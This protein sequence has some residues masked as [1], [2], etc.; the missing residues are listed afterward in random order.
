MME[1]DYVLRVSQLNEYVNGMLRRETLLQHIGVRGEISGLKYHASGH[2]YFSLKDE[3]ALLRC[4]MFKTYAARLTCTLRDGM[5]IVT[6]GSVSLFVR[7]GQF[8]LY[9]EDVQA[10]GEGELYRRFLLMKTRLEAQGLFDAAHKRPLPLLPRRIG[11]VTSPSGAVIHDIV[12]VAGRRF[13]TMPILLCPVQV[14]GPGAAEEI[15]A[16]IRY[17][18]AHR[19]ADVLIV[20]RGGGSM[21]DLWAFNEETVARAIYESAIPVVSAVGHETDVSIADYV[22]DQR[23]P[24]P[25]AA[26]ELCV[27]VYDELHQRAQ[28]CGMRMR[29]AMNRA[30]QREKDRMTG[31]RGSAG[32][33]APRHRLLKLKEAARYQTD[34]LKRTAKE[35][36]MGGAALLDALTGRLEALSPRRVLSSGYVLV[37]G[38][39]GYIATARGLYKDQNVE[40]IW[41]DGTARAAITET[42]EER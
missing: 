11:V 9:V 37:K 27:P 4:V 2:I 34:I 3:A 19:L 38:E 35:Q 17:M 28:D 18:N 31:L 22:A 25:S 14:Q 16:G 24:T 41:A 15:A 39:K 30:L 26:A 29:L 7:D 10:Q 36:I 8:Q 33:A 40:L 21:E 23:A 6:Y 42:G 1:N 20:G 12:N 13:P 5:Q 32:M